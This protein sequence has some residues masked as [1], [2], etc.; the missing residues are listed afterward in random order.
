MYLLP[1]FSG[2][3]FVDDW[4][5]PSWLP[6]TLHLAILYL[7]VHTRTLCP[8]LILR[9]SRAEWA[10]PL[11]LYLPY[12]PWSQPFLGAGSCPFLVGHLWILI[13]AFREVTHL[14]L[15]KPIS[16][17]CCWTLL[18]QTACWLH[19]G[20]IAFGCY[21]C[22]QP[23]GSMLGSLHLDVIAAVCLL[24]PCWVLFSLRAAHALGREE[25]CMQCC[26]VSTSLHCRYPTDCVV[27]RKLVPVWSSHLWWPKLTL[28][29][30]LMC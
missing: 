29:T 8:I 30:L 6:P 1:G 27:H 18:L 3:D 16:N 13:Q 28:S 21:C 20:S 11:S 22:R 23:V 2:Q 24:A 17:G 9:N 5:P 12:L 4:Y 25:L 10:W 19:V 7:S 14:S 15:S 26:T